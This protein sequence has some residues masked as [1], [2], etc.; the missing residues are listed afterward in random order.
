MYLIHLFIIKTAD[1]AAKSISE[2]ETLDTLGDYTRRRGIWLTPVC[3][4]PSPA[5]DGSSGLPLSG[6]S[7]GS[8]K[9]PYEQ[10]SPENNVSI[11]KNM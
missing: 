10:A 11:Y 8:V 3:P 6:C 9:T 5:S 2:S 4:R 7:S 1:T